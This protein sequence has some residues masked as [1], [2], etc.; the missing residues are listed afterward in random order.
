MTPYT[1]CIIHVTVHIMFAVEYQLCSVHVRMLYFY[2]IVVVHASL[3]CVLM[4]PTSIEKLSSSF[5]ELQYVM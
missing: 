4:V 5:E 2:S 3:V 1:Y